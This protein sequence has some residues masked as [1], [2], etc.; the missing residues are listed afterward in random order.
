MGK[1][2]NSERE[3]LNAQPY[4]MAAMTDK[5]RPMKRQTI[6]I[7][8]KLLGP[9]HKSLNKKS[10]WVSPIISVMFQRKTSQPAFFF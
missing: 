3:I 4:K 10:F 7:P 8:L 1:C 9:I 5:K 6:F 2:A